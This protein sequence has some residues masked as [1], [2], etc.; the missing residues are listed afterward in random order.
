MEKP[1]ITTTR[2]KPNISHVDNLWIV[3]FRYAYLSETL[4]ENG[5]FAY[6]RKSS[7]FLPLN[8]T[9]DHIYIKNTSRVCVDEF[10]D[11]TESDVTYQLPHF[12]QLCWASIE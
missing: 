7:W 12:P 1:K 2:V 5:D 9:Y 8:P 4:L 3:G 6:N 11:S 10:T